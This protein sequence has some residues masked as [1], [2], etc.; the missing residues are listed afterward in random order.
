MLGVDASL[1]RT[2][3][4]LLPPHWLLGDWSSVRTMSYPTKP[5]DRKALSVL[6][7]E[8]ARCA[9]IESIA[10]AVGDFLDQLRVEPGG[11]RVAGFVENYGFNA[12]GAGAHQLPELGMAIRLELRRRHG[13]TL[14]PVAEAMVR[15]QLLGVIPRGTDRKLAVQLAFGAA[16]ARFNS[17]ECDAVAIAC[18]GLSEV[19]A[20]ALYLGR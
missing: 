7:Y 10:G 17:D 15:K 4:A 3:A 14:Y 20:T 9:R 18:F 11:G 12:G 19:G 1:T 13:V 5:P 6:E 2:A 16:G 8:D